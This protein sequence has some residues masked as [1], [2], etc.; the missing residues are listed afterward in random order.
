MM[1]HVA[2][3]PSPKQYS[4]FLVDLSEA[5]ASLDTGETIKRICC[6]PY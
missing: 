2:G 5:A 3:N 6:S 4:G 1:L